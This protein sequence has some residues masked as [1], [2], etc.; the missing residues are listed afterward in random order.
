MLTDAL[1]AIVN[2]LW[3]MLTSAL[4]VLVNNSF[5]ESFD[6]AFM[7]NEKSYQNINF[8]FLFL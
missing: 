4:R 3:V 6:T 5:Y 7:R 2:K 8:F 1:I